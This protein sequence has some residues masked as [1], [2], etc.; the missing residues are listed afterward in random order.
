MDPGGPMC[1]TVVPMRFF[2]AVLILLSGA[3]ESRRIVRWNPPLG[4]LPGA[5]SGM[6]VVDDTRFDFAD[7]TQAPEGGIRQ[8][9]D[10]GSIRLY[11]RSA[12][13]LM[14]HIYTTLVNDERDLFAQQVLSEITRQEFIERGRDP[15]EAFDMLKKHEDDIIRLFDRMPMGEYTPGVVW[16]NI[17]RVGNT[18]IVRLSITGLGASQMRY[19][20]MDMAM[21]HGNWRLRWFGP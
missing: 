9:L 20:F 13:H 4:N 14:S 18:N 19:T 7:P 12:R 11:A 16:K 10:D 21:E 3:C 6:P 8:E 2:L 5:V 15:R 1:R 17:G